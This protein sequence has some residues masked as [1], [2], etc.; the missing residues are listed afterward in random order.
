MM[1]GGVSARGSVRRSV[2][3]SVG[4]DYFPSLNEDTVEKFM[5]TRAF[6]LLAGEEREKRREGRIILR[7]AL[8]K[9]LRFASSFLPPSFNFDKKQ[10]T[11][12]TG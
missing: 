2:G 9:V 5:G 10:H 6:V 8:M 4:R 3:R 1:S 12:M 7:R 11:P